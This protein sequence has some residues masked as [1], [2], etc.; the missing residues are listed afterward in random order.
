MTL[1]GIR[2]PLM[3]PG[4]C[5]SM[6]LARV[7]CQGGAIEYR[8]GCSRKRAGSAAPQL[9]GCSNRDRGNLHSVGFFIGGPTGTRSICGAPGSLASPRWLV[10]RHM[11]RATGQ[12]A[13][14]VELWTQQTLSSGR[15]LVHL[16]RCLRDDKQASTALEVMAPSEERAARLGLTTRGEPKVL[17][18]LDD[19]VAEA[20]AWE[21]LLEAQIGFCSFH[22][23]VDGPRGA[24]RTAERAYHRAVRGFETAFPVEWVAKRRKALLDTV[25]TLCADL[26][27]RDLGDEG[28]PEE[29]E[30]LRQMIEPGIRQ[31]FTQ[32]EARL[33]P[34]TPAFKGIPD[35][36][37][38]SD[39][40]R[41][42]TDGFGTSP[43]PW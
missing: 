16:Y 28:S 22:A 19:A 34:S 2:R 21:R 31:G 15:F 17:E 41:T 35:M 43:S 24:K 14:Q 13:R 27:I 7:C 40:L 23:M 12:L 20:H 8:R 32:A 36:V 39:W 10:C 4:G 6:K 33:K 38:E 9:P 18:F 37:N 5:I 42:G 26:F 11:K 1:C 3:R 30:E 29:R 25:S